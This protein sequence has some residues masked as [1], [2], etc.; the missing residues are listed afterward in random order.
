ML[1][2]SPS[3]MSCNAFAPEVRY[4]MSVAALGPPEELPVFM[5]K[6]LRKGPTADSTAPTAPP[7]ELLPEPA[8]G[9]GR[10]DVATP[11]RSLTKPV[12]LSIKSGVE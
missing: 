10:N 9:A 4:L 1:D 11:A 5:P 12:I 2:T 6:M 7:G 3:R 8:E